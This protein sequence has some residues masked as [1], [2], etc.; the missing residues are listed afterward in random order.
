MHA[1]YLSLRN[2][3]N[4]IQQNLQFC[5]CMKKI[6][7]ILITFM[8][9]ASCSGNG[10]TS[11]SKDSASATGPVSPERSNPNPKPMAT[12]SEDIN[13]ETGRLNH[14]KFM[15]ALYE[16]N[17]TF[18]YRV[19]VQ[20]AELNITD[21][22]QLPDLGFMPKPALQKGKEDYSCII[23]FMDN[24]DVFRDYKLVSVTDGSLRIHTLKYYGVQQTTT[25]Q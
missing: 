8:I 2:I 11:S 19:K 9:L 25:G 7:Y 18:M 12:Y 6:L 15:V 3:S 23:G 20:Y 16:T 21:S 24:K 22:L 10:T 5:N 1:I 14:W 17:K 4:Y 13:T